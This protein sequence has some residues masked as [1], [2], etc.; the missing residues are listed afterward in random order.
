MFIFVYRQFIIVIQVF[1]LVCFIFLPLLF[2]QYTRYECKWLPFQ[3]LVNE[4][5]R[6]VC[7]AGRKTHSLTHSLVLVV[8]HLSQTQASLQ[9]LSIF[10]HSIIVHSARMSSTYCS[11]FMVSQTTV[12]RRKLYRM[13]HIP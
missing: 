2:C 10:Y 3:R 7:G 11:S 4:L 5:T 13:A 12:V 8:V 6:N 9:I 1:A